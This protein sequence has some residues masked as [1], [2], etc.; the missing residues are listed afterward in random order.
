MAGLIED[1]CLPAS[2]FLLDNYDYRGSGQQ[3]S[4]RFIFF[5]FHHSELSNLPIPLLEHKAIST[6]DL[7]VERSD[8]GKVAVSAILKF[9]RKA[10]R[11]II[12]SSPCDNYQ[13]AILDVYHIAKSIKYEE[14]DNPAKTLMDLVSVNRKL[15]HPSFKNIVDIGI[16]SYVSSVVYKGVRYDSLPCPSKMEALKSLASILDKLPAHSKPG[17]NKKVS[18]KKPTSQAKQTKKK[19]TPS[20]TSRPDQN[21]ALLIKYSIKRWRIEH[22][23]LINKKYKTKKEVGRVHDLS[24]FLA[25]TDPLRKYEVSQD[26]RHNTAFKIEKEVQKT[27]ERMSSEGIKQYMS[28]YLRCLVK[29][30]TLLPSTNVVV[31]S[32]FIEKA[33]S[34]GDNPEEII[35]RFVKNEYLREDYGK[36]LLITNKGI[37]LIESTLYS[38]L[39]NNSIGSRLSPDVLLALSKYAEQS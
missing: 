20:A 10:C 32:T 3:V 25:I 33:Y 11:T 18:T 34:N 24:L 36:N 31:D 26:V 21:T 17:T 30:H 39:K 28:Q 29:S 27:A 13:D 4:D 15:A 7:K 19:S 12:E 8:S 16:P 35:D 6:P 5:G 14:F 1:D 23:W 37:K 9:G 38:G 2:S 22:G